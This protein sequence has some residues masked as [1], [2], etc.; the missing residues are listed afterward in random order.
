MLIIFGVWNPVQISHFT[1]P[2]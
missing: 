2:E 1:L